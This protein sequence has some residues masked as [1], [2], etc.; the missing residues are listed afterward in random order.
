MKTFPICGPRKIGMNGEVLARNVLLLYSI[1][2]S[3]L[4][5]LLHKADI[6]LSIYKKTMN[7]MNIV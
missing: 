2:K 4:V 5:L 3:F 6:P 1:V 7:E